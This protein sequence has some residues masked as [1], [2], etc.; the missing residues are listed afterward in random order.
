MQKHQKDL[1][2]LALFPGDTFSGKSPCLLVMEGLPAMEGPIDRGFMP[3][4]V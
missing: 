3:G 2:S 4:T 1:R